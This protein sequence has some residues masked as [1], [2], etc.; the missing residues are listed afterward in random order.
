MG[1]EGSLKLQIAMLLIV[2]R[3]ESAF[4]SSC[5]K[6]QRLIKPTEL[7]G[8]VGPKDLHLVGPFLKERI[9]F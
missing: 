9:I 2:V 3:I 4:I 8:L 5:K 1:M 6:S 7:P